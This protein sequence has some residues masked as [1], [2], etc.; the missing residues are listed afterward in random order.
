MTPLFSPS[1]PWAGRALLLTGLLLLP[2]AGVVIREALH[3]QHLEYQISQTEQ[4]FADHQRTLRRLQEAQQR[5][6]RQSH[7]LEAIPPAIR[8]MDSVGSALS[9]EIA[10]LSIDITPMG[11]DVRLTVNATSLNTLLAFSE[12]LQQLPARVVLENHRPSTNDDP[13]WPLVASLDVH[14]SAEEQHES[15]R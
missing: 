7:Q 15:G 10:L 5:R 12:R 1:A 2:V 14:F 13:D 3:H 9:P 8:M 6:Q 4:R 11:R